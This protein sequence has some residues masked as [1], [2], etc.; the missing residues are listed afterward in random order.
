M[1]RFADRFRD[2]AP[3]FD[4]VLSDVWGVIHNGVAAFPEAC[5]ALQAFRENGGTVVMITNAPR[6]S[7]P[8]VDFLRGLKIS[9]ETYDAIV[10]SGDVTTHYIAD[11]RG[12]KP[13]YLGPQRDRAIYDNMKIDFVPLEDADYIIDVG[14]VHEETEHPDDYRGMLQKGVARRMPM[15]C[16]NPDLVVERGDKLVFC[17]GSLAELYRNLGGEVIFAGK[18]HRPIYDQALATALEKRKARG[19]GDGKAPRVLAIG[20]SVRT[21]LEGANSFGI[22]CLFV[23]SLIHAADFG[24]HDDPDEEAMARLFSSASKPPIAVTRRLMW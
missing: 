20:D 19:E 1:I 9:D 16:A 22:P 21:D 5:E 2:L 17:A 14:L 3:D 23:I 15:I 12:Q 24:S 6:P 18:P 13:Y 11:H 8:V 7:A 10:S 4:I